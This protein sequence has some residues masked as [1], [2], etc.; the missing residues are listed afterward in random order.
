MNE[1][2]LKMLKTSLFNVNKLL[3]KSI[4]KTCQIVQMS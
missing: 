3:I 2:A 4:K 1:K